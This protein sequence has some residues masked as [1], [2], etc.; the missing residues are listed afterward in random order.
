MQTKM[1]NTLKSA[2]LPK[3]DFNIY[4]TNCI[5]G[6]KFADDADLQEILDLRKDIQDGCDN[7]IDC[8]RKGSRWS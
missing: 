1:E 4:D 2:G 3:I 6:G 8:I 7:D 5:T